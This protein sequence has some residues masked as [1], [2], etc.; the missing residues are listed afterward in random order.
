MRSTSWAMPVARSCPVSSHRLAI[1]T[2]WSGVRSTTPTPGVFVIGPT[3]HCT[4]GVFTHPRRGR[5]HPDL[6]PLSRPDSPVQPDVVVGGHPQPLGTTRIVTRPLTDV[7]E[8]L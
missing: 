8:G 1:A 3:S 6:T 2:N 5:S 7:S 4:I